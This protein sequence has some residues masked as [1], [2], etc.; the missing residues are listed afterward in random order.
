MPLSPSYPKVVCRDTHLSTL[1]RTRARTLL[2]FPITKKA[3]NDR[4]RRTGP[5]LS[6]STT[7]TT[8][9]PESLTFS[10]PSLSSA[11]TALLCPAADRQPLLVLLN[12]GATRLSQGSLLCAGR[13]PHLTGPFG[14][15][16]RDAIR[17]APVSHED[18]Y[19]R[20][21]HGHAARERGASPR[22]PLEHMP[23]ARGRH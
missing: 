20:Q 19:G 1:I 6:L 5:P 8:I 13:A 22:C 21:G 10:C 3:Q 11:Y 17:R 16:R 7:T 15:K 23:A 14:G 4:E 2:S 18:A 9:V 12:R